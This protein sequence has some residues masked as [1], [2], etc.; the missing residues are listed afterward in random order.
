M[1]TIL[2]TGAAGFIG[3][4]F[5]RLLLRERGE[6]RVIALDALTYAGNLHNLADSS[7]NPRYTFVRG[8]I[9][10]Q[11][12][13]EP[14]FAAGL[15]AVV[16]FAAETH[17]DR[18]IHGATAF[19]HANILGVQTMLD[20]TRTYE[21]PRFLQVSTD[22]V[23]GSLGETGKFTEATPLAPNSPYS[24][25]KASADMLVQAYHHTF[26][27]PTLITR[28]S[29]NYGP[30]QFPEKLIP[31]FV[32]NLLEGRKVPLYGDGLNVRDWVHVDDH[33]EAILAVLEKAT[34]GSVYNIGGDRELPN[35]EIARRILS[36][37]ERDEN[38]IEYVTDRPGHDRRYAMDIRRIAA[39]LGWRPRVDFE[40]GIADTIDWYVAN[41][42]WWRRIKTGEYQ[43]YYEKQYGPGGITVP[44]REANE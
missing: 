42:D 16:N 23:Y 7:E 36:H 9:C 43:T 37:L 21:V 25:S 34:P 10:D 3:S 22:E 4:N 5:V 38:W 31:L 32:T 24:A 17:V 33:C 44:K 39:D 12:V 14:L 26:G 27:L 8:D 15:D 28:C 35:I 1:S 30:Y 29:N 19:V 11:T 41:E 18:S 13:L 40:R 2:V 20:L 6:V